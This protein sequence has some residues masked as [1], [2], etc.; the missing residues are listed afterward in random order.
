MKILQDCEETV[1]LD[2]WRQ[3]TSPANSTGSSPTPT[4][5]PMIRSLHEQSVI[6]A[7][8]SDRSCNE[9]DKDHLWDSGM[10]ESKDSKTVRH[11]GSQTDSLDSPRPHHRKNNKSSNQKESENRSRY[12][13]SD[14]F[15][16]KAWEF[17]TKGR[18]SKY[19]DR[20]ER[21]ASQVEE[22]KVIA[23]FNAVISLHDDYPSEKKKELDH[24]NSGTWPKY[25][26]MQ[27]N[28]SNQ[29]T[30]IS[31][32]SQKRKDRP[33]LSAIL[34]D[35]SVPVSS[36]SPPQPILQSD[37]Y[38]KAPTTPAERTTSSF[39][40][41]VQHSP[42]NSEVI[43][44]SQT[45][46]KQ[47]LNTNTISSIN[48][49]LTKSVP[50]TSAKEH[51]QMTMPDTRTYLTHSV[52]VHP[53]PATFD[54]SLVDGYSKGMRPKVTLNKYD[55]RFYP[56]QHGINPQLNP[57][58]LNNSNTGS[59]SETHSLLIPQLNW[60]LATSL[61]SSVSPS[62]DSVPVT[63]YRISPVGVTPAVRPQSNYS[64]R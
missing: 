61:S 54:R 52:P 12:S 39:A 55:K 32:S 13:T 56:P 8:M 18:H 28:V 50:S 7:A 44:P 45:P 1:V 10:E 47:L 35:T 14:K 53:S 16:E 3:T 48:P 17:L 19:S 21:N 51:L 4:C 62:I 29:G 57:N 64:N 33:P 9:A 38:N 42:Q 15:L 11:N 30:V 25:R 40:H 63:K 24:E 34:S 5:Q 41:S 46:N 20:P 43:C 49:H 31:M 60:S 6:S 22:D 59:S 58:N 26:G 23:E 36:S 37:L 2:V 27:T